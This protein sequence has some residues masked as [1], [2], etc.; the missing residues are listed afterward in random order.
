LKIW[1]IL[2]GYFASL[3]QVNKRKFKVK[4]ALKY[5]IIFIKI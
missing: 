2:R 4:K 1:H 3:F 5:E